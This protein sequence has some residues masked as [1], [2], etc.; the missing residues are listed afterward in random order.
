MSSLWLGQSRRREH[1]DTATNKEI[2]WRSA[3]HRLQLRVS[4]RR[5]DDERQVNPLV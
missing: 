2:G 5:V 3:S 1:L 4:R